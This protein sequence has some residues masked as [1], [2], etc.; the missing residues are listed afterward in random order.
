MDH[1]ERARRLLERARD[2][3]RSH[4]LV[5]DLDGLAAEVREADASELVSEAVYTV[6]ADSPELFVRSYD[7]LF[8]DL[9]SDD[10][11]VR[12]GAAIT[13]SWLA[14]H[15]PDELVDRVPELI[16]LLRSP[17]QLIRGS[18]VRALRH[19]AARQ[20][21]ATATATN[22]LFAC[23]EDDNPW[24]RG[25]ACYALGHLGDQRATD[26]LRELLVD[27]ALYVG[28]AAEWGLGRLDDDWP[29]PDATGWE[30]R[31]LVG[32]DDRAL[33][34]LVAQLWSQYGYE[35]ELTHETRT[36]GFDVTAE[37]GAERSLIRIERY[38]PYKH[39]GSITLET[40]QR[41]AGMLA[42]DEFDR[43]VVVT[44][45]HFSSDAVGFA[46]R[47]DRV[48]LVDG[49]QLCDLLSGEGFA[50][51]SSVPATRGARTTPQQSD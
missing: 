13:F 23:L 9:G 14:E 41:V 36:D 39:A 33:E 31:H 8:V 40:V 32:Y 21:A 43:V 30:L 24:V 19:V 1:E 4:A 17:D 5:R 34:Q 47:T 28:T 46:A 37:D 16:G 26:W 50:T 2:G 27:R 18:A 51:P 3:E 20:P 7:A 35:T 42:M 45:S 11:E 38:N 44:N 22:A 10:D 12:A 15:P 49:G 29:A 48:R 25:E 6:L